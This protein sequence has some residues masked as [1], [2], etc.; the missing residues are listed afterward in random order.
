MLS[1]VKQ[2]TEG[3]STVVKA[4][5]SPNHD[6]CVRDMGIDQTSEKKIEKYP[7]LVALLIHYN[8]S[9]VGER[10][11]DRRKDWLAGKQLI[12]VEPT[13]IRSPYNKCNEINKFWATLSSKLETED[14]KQKRMKTFGRVLLPAVEYNFFHFRFTEVLFTLLWPTVKSKGTTIM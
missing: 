12:Y 13:L 14:T 8:D 7:Y 2:R 3:L 1:E 10:T 4:M 6:I 9:N 5:H 11:A